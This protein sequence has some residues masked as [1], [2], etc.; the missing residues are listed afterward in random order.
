MGLPLS[1]MA[2]PRPVEPALGRMPVALL[3]AKV[4]LVIDTGVCPGSASPSQSA[5]PWPTTVFAENVLPE[6]VRRPF[7]WKMAPPFVVP[8]LPA[9]VQSSTTRAEGSPYIQEWI[10]PPRF[11]A[12]L[13][14]KV[15]RRR[16]RAPRLVPST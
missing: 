9:N 8:A 11:V 16:V 5:P 15:V 14:A 10:A 3:P 2:P 6:I 13:P 4:E 7:M 1:R 12:R